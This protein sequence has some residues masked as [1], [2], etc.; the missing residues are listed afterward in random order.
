MTKQQL[1]GSVQLYTKP[2]THVKRMEN[3]NCNYEDGRCYNRRNN[4][5]SNTER[6]Y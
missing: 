2:T 6:N 4:C 3:N 5:Q 1:Q